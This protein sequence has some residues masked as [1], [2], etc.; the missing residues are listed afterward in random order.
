ADLHHEDPSRV[1]FAVSGPENPRPKQ[2]KS[3]EKKEGE[4]LSSPSGKIVYAA[5]ISEA[6]DELR[7]PSSSL[8][9]SG[10]AA[11][12]SMGFSLIAE[13]LLRSHLPDTT[14]Q[15]LVSK[16]GYPI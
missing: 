9:F 1:W 4:R 13:A 16:L 8:F 3:H 12:L 10:L 6:E 11:G 7:R 15:P 2:A 14:W 5:I